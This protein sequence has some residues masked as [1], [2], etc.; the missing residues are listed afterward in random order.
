MALFVGCISEISL[1]VRLLNSQSFN[2]GRPTGGVAAT[3][4]TSYERRKEVTPLVKINLVK[5]KR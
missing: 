1:P 5:I 3:M 2:C 4:R